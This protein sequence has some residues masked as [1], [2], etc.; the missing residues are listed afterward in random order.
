LGKEVE[1]KSRR[2]LMDLGRKFQ[3]TRC[4][5]DEDVRSRSSKPTYLHKQLSALGHSASVDKYAAVL[6][7]FLSPCYDDPLDS[8]TSSSDIYK[9]RALQKELKTL[10][11]AFTAK[12]RSPS[13]GQRAA[14]TREGQRN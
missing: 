3:V 6:M 5:E 10:E 1:R 8:L 14:E 9:Q 2:V 13:A 7:G 11:E 12:P 4:G